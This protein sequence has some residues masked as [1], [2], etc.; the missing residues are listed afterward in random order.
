M[1]E[2]LSKLAEEIANIDFFNNK[3][4]EF[5][6]SSFIEEHQAIID[7]MPD[8][9]FTIDTSYFKMMYHRT[10]ENL[11]NKIGFIPR[12]IYMN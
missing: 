3:K 5:K 7:R 12:D 10:W 11:L 1:Y 6:H 8:P 9:G 2:W 4:M